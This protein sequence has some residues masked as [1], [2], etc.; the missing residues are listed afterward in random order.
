VQGDH[1]LAEL[2]ASIRLWSKT[3]PFATK[4]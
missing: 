3:P 4:V 2:R 1:A